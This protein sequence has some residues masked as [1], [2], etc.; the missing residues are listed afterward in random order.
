MEVAAL[1]LSAA[2]LIAKSFIDAA[3]DETG[4]GAWAGVRRLTDLVR[5]RIGGT[6]RPDPLS[7]VESNPED[8]P[9]AQALADFLA[10]QAEHDEE[11]RRQLEALVTEAD[12]HEPV[13][14]IVNEFYGSVRIGKQVNI[15]DVHGSVSF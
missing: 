9:A 13:A 3:A 8:R 12:R 15:G 5:S 11:F 1:A 7:R 2:T 14:A 10:G 4:R 6:A